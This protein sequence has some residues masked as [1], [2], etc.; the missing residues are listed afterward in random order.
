[1]LREP[2]KLRNFYKLAITGNSIM[3]Q[4]VM[5]EPRVTPSELHFKTVLATFTAHGSW[6]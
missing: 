4:S 3:Q 6:S 2:K 5:V 1:M